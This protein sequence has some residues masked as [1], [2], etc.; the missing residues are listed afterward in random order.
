M[1]KKTWRVIEGEC[2]ICGGTVSFLIQ[3]KATLLREASCS[4]CGASIR[5]SDLAKGILDAFGIRERSLK[6]ALPK[7]SG[8]RILNTCS[9]GKI[10]DCL[11]RLP[12]YV[13]SEYFDDVPNGEKKG[14]V[15]SADL[16]NL[17][18]A[19]E[20]FDLV[21]S[22]DVFEHISDYKKA[23]SEVYRVLNAGGYH[24][25]T[26]PLHEGKKTVSR[27][28]NE[29]RIYHGDPIREEGAL[30]I[31][32]FG[33]DLSD[34]LDNMKFSTK[35]VMGHKFYNQN[36]ITDAD[37]SYEEFLLKMDRMD[38]YFKYNSVVF[39]S[40]KEMEI[41]H[42]FLRRLFLQDLLEEQKLKPSKELAEKYLE[43]VS[44]QGFDANA[45]LESPDGCYAPEGEDENKFAWAGERVS[46]FLKLEENRTLLH[47]KGY[48]NMDMYR[49]ENIDKLLL[50]LFVNQKACE[51]AKV[52]FTENGEVNIS[53]DL[54]E[55][56]DMQYVPVEILA[57]NSVCPKMD[58][59][60]EDERR[61]SW[62]LNKIEMK[63]V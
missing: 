61:I 50:Q 21:I 44:M 5:N 39:V 2:Y 34:I 55:Y 27:I 48:V 60:G 47:I 57:S 28:G 10:H 35:V 11:H 7:L 26:V 33:S 29:K 41:S 62:I 20:S 58:G 37:T 30:V 17:P 25:F 45:D 31:T 16:M 23:F 19:D 6:S 13:A 40:K 51:E 36:E 46:F 4:V 18:F 9:S 1:E 24:I 15:V 49:A 14:N 3:R 38:E 8:Y 54:K 52:V 63:S 43:C 53:V 32:D 12:G 22:E 56:L 42:H 59:I